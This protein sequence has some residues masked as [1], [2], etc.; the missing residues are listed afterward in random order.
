MA[1]TAAPQGLRRCKRSASF[2]ASHL[3]RSVL[4]LDCRLTVGRRFVL[5]RPTPFDECRSGLA[6]AKCYQIGFQRSTS[7]ET[8]RNEL[9]ALRRMERD[10]MAGA[11]ADHVPAIVACNDE[12]NDAIIHMT[13]NSQVGRVAGLDGPEDRFDGTGSVFIPLVEQEQGPERPCR[14]KPDATLRSTGRFGP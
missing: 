8:C 9:V 14:R 10:V 6:E 4:E 11:T 1:G 2:P 7:D 5:S 13:I 3:D 12:R